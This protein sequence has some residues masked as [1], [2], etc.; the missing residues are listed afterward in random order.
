M[1]HLHSCTNVQFSFRCAVA[2]LDMSDAA[3]QPM[4]LAAGKA[5]ACDGAVRIG[6]DTDRLAARWLLG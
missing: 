4:D 2:G 1:P 5:A 3:V 6:F